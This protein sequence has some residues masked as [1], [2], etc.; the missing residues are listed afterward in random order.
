MPENLGNDNASVREDR[1]VVKV[2]QTGEDVL[3]TRSAAEHQAIADYVSS[4][5]PVFA[6]DRLAPYRPAGG[7]DLAMVTNYFWNIALSRDFYLVLSAVEISMRNGIHRA[8]STHANRDDW[9][10]VIP[11]LDRERERVEKRRRIS[12]SQASTSFRGELLPAWLSIF[13]RVC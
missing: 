11:L 2:L 13:G 4:L 9:Y 10:S 3:M 8:L 7:D 1:S 12:A 6:P 5:Q